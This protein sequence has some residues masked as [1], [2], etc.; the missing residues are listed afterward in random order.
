MDLTK[1]VIDLQSHEGNRAIANA[2]AG[3]L[4]MTSSSSYVGVWRKEVPLFQGYGY[5]PT[6]AS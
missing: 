1:K 5:S 3:R 2:A 6:L 4:V